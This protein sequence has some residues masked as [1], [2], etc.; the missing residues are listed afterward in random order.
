M[1]KLGTSLTTLALRLKLPV[2]EIIK[3]TLFNQFCGGESI[4]DCEKTIKVLG[5]HNVKTILDYSVEGLKNE[6][7]YNEA[8]EEA[9]R[10]VDFAAES[11]HIPFCVLKLSGLGPTELMTKAQEKKEL[12][13]LEK[14]KLHYCEERVNEI[15]QKVYDKGLRLM[16]DAEETWVQDFMDGVAIRLMKKFNKERP[17]VYTTYQMY[18][19]DSLDRL[20]LD[21]AIGVNE[22]Y[23]FGVKLVRGAYMERERRRAVEL[24]YDSPIHPD[25]DAVDKDYNASLEFC[26]NNIERIGVCNGTHNEES[27][28]FL[29]HL[30]E[31]AGLEKND[32]RIY[33]SQ[34]LGMSDNISFILGKEGYNVSKYVPYGP[35][36]KV[37]PYLFRRAKENTSVAGQISREYLLVKNEIS[38]RRANK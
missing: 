33:F 21:Y 14:T 38:R 32:E 20:K 36:E 2:K 19:H 3:K 22:G 35:V 29:A 28:R 11:E 31:E 10:N 30:M 6:D 9:L 13:E 17:V 25:K 7:G 8:K 34:L 23:Y 12:T 26:I 4:K 15:A 16:I 37:M 1:V 18:R 24:G 5:A 27:S